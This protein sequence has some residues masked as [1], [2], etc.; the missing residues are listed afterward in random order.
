MKYFR[1]HYFYSSL[2]LI[3]NIFAVTA[4]FK[5]IPE[6]R[7]A[8]TIAGALFIFWPLL[9][10]YWEWI[11]YKKTQKL[12]WLWLLSLLQFLILF[13]IP[14]FYTRVVHWNSEFQSL[15]IA[16]IPAESMHRYANKSYSIMLLLGLAQWVKFCFLT[17]KN[18]S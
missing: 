13:A 11:F 14:I 18:K 1:S 4:L 2:I 12:S 7:W 5:I 16:G 8:A 10:M 9:L 3:L 6:R 17:T 15:F